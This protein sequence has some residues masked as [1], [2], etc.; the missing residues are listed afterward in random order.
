M[1][2]LDT[3]YYRDNELI[4]GIDEAGR[5]P[6]AGP[7]V[8]A[9][10][11]VKTGFTIPGLDDSKKLTDKKRRELFK[12][13]KENVIASHIMVISEAEIDEINIL[14]ATMKG[15]ANAWHGLSTKGKILVDGNRLPEDLKQAD[16]EAI[17]KGDGKVSAIAAA[18]ILA[19]VT[20]DD[21][22]IN[23]DKEFPEY[24]FAR[25]KGYGTAEHLKAIN[26]HGIT[27]CH[28]KT[29]GPVAQMKLDI[30]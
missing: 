29:Y 1:L 19:K 26:T 9:A 13:I 25:N 30:F 10:V 2:E 18:S 11:T 21:I 28:R 7:L 4:T 15:M 3:S 8:V 16:A 24:G 27:D 12:I 20:R 14:A 22:M 6:L 5:G 17:V 23:L